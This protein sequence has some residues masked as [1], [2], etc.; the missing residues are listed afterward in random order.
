MTPAQSAL[1]G[2]GGADLATG[3]EPDAPAG[4]TMLRRYLL[5]LAAATADPVAMMGGRV[6]RRDDLVAADLGRPAGY[7]NSAILLAPLTEASLPAMMRDL[8]AFFR[9][10]RPDEHGMVV[11]FSAWPTPDLRPFGWGLMG[12]PPLHL[13]PPGGGRPTPPAGLTIEEIHD[14]DGL[15]AFERVAVEGYPLDELRP[16]MPGSLLSTKLLTDRRARFWVGSVAGEPVSGASAFVEAGIVDVTFVATMPH[17]RRNGYGEAVTWAATLAE[18][19][20]PAMLLSSDPGRPVYERMGYLP[21]LRFSLW[22][23]HRPDA[24]AAR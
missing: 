6:L 18:P 1:P 23:R 3:W 4:D 9:L 17:A 16:L 5:N 7:F 15:R 8:A 13:R 11:I 19:T 12:H 21:L 2:A 22:F 10:D 24:V 14:E 20:L